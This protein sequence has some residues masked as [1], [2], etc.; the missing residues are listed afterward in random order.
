MRAAAVFVCMVVVIVATTLGRPSASGP[1]AQPA[2]TDLTGVVLAAASA[3][4]PGTT[5]ANVRSDADWILQA[6]LPDGALTH[7]V[8]RVAIWPYL[9]NQAATGLARA[10]EVTGDPR[11]AAAAWSWL[12]WYQAHQDS[13]GFVTDYTVSPAGVETSTGD[14]DSTDAYAGTFLTA[15]ARAFRA[16]GNTAQLLRLHPGIVA[17]VGAIETTQDVDGLTWAKPAWHVKY[18]MDQGEAYAGLRAAHQ[19]AGPLGDPALDHRATADASRMLSGVGTLWNNATASYGWAKHSDGVV[20]PANWGVLYSDALEEAWAV[21]YGLVT[22]GKAQSLMQQF[23]VSQPLWSSP[24]A[25]AVENA[26]PATVGYWPQ[27]GLALLQTGQTSPALSAAGSIRSAALASNRA[28]PYTT[29]TAGA[30]ILL[31]SADT[32]YLA[33]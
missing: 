9:A 8:D 10:T 33:G 11:Y 4:S 7:Y 20:V 19:L 3:P 5:V 32:H 1:D 29:G 28:W 25:V 2:S 17:A 24:T 23:G 26:G 22:G 18:L 21:T 30:L 31:E 6:Q 27:A 13:Q 14:M 16:T 12:A 15:V